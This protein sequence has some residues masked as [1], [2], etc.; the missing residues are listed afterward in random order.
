MMPLASGVRVWLATGSHGYEKGLCDA[1]AAGAGS[2]AARYFEPLSE[3]L[4]CFCGRRG[5]LL[6]VI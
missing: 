2:A 4:F 5:D 1:I 3:H 6:K